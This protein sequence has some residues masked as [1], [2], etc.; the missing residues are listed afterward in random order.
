MW[1]EVTFEVLTTVD[2]SFLFMEMRLVLR[3]AAERDTYIAVRLFLLIATISDG[4]NFYWIA[5]PTGVIALG[6]T[7]STTQGLPLTLLT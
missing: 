1:M 4:H 6:T 5:K 3:N 2:I 7:F